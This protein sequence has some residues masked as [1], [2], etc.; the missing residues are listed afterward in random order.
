[1]RPFEFRVWD[2]KQKKWIPFKISLMCFIEQP[3]H[4]FTIF[5]EN[6]D[7]EFL[8]YTGSKDIN[9]VKIFEGDFLKICGEIVL[10]EWAFDGF[11]LIRENYLGENLFVHTRSTDGDSAMWGKVVGNR[12]EH[13]YKDFEK[14]FNGGA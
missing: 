13:N 4:S 1:M 10:V 9:G 8:Q 7:L 12:L 6:K 14:G 2:K 3:N 11:K 5:I